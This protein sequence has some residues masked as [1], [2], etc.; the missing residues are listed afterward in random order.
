MGK[1]KM[2]TK[3]GDFKPKNMYRTADMS[4]G[5]FVIYQGVY[6]RKYNLATPGYFFGL[7]QDGDGFV[8]R[9][10]PLENGWH[11]LGNFEENMLNMVEK[12]KIKRG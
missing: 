1:Y 10:L 4:I 5:R 6:D 2:C 8:L 12:N 11:D 3:Y 7:V 9:E